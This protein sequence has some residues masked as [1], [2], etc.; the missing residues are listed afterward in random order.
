VTATA[1]LAGFAALVAVFGMRDLVAGGLVLPRAL[2]VAHTLAALVEVVMALGRE[3]R[4]P[5]AVERRRLLLAGAAAA[6]LAGCLVVGPVAGLALGAGGPWLAARLLR[7]RR[8]RFRR[9][10]DAGVPALA[11]AVADALAGGHSLRGALGEAARSVGG[12]VGH[13]LRRVEAELAVGAATDTALEAVRNRVRSHRLDTVVAACV[14]QRKAGG[15]LAR[16]LRESARAMEE[17][18]RLEGELRA[19]TAQARFTGV[20][21]AG[22][23]LGGAA[24]AELASPGWLAGLWSSFLTAWLVGIALALQLTAAFLIRRLG[25][26]RW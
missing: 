1:T 19:A 4:D 25:R 2:R 15:D 13:E 20:L 3:G 14:L 5:G 18:A 21:V 16:L 23:P 8:E 11:L 26:V 12:A 9:A 22:L 10:V 6:F 17:Q 24:L 7:A